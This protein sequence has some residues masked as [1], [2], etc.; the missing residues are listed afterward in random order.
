MI[1]LRIGKFIQKGISQNIDFT[2]LSSCQLVLYVNKVM[3]LLTTCKV[4]EHEVYSCVS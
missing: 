3:A 4:A 1:I 2:V